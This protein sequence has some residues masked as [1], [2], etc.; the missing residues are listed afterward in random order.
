[1]SQKLEDILNELLEDDTK[2]TVT[3]EAEDTKEEEYTDEET[4]ALV[5]YL[6]EDEKIAEEGSE[7]EP[8]DEEVEE[9]L[10]S[11]LGNDKEAEDS[12]NLI[13]K[14]IVDELVEEMTKEAM[15]RKNKAI[16][17]G[18]SLAAGGAGLG[19]ALSPKAR[20]RAKNVYGETKVRAKN[21]YG[22]ALGRP[23]NLQ[24]KVE[25]VLGQKVTGSNIK[26]LLKK[27]R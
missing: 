27:F 3:K 21:V 15:S 24:A 10:T 25:K 26:K 2:E 8:T 16:I 18:G 20:T 23:A 12:E 5:D 6:L 14:L 19:F 11:L 22:A 7:E 13:N 9:Y 1:M 4:A 17:A